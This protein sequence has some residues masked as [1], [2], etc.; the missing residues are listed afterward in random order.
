MLFTGTT[1]HFLSHDPG[2]DRD[3]QQ[4]F[5]GHLRQDG[6]KPE[7]NIE[8]WARFA[9]MLMDMGLGLVGVESKHNFFDRCIEAGWASVATIAITKG[10]KYIAD[11]KRP[12][13]EDVSFPSGH[14]STSFVGAELTRMEYGNAWGAGAYAI[15]GTVGTMRLYNNWHW[16]S[17]VLTGAGIGILSAHIGEWL[18]EPTKNLLGIDTEGKFAIS[19]SVDPASGTLCA[20]FAMQF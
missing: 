6:Q 2:L 7:V 11:T 19:P 14:S 18:I 10:I 4:F 8:N 20:S 12:N 13:G 5:Y 15:A 17:D 3:V 16:L 1:I 9:P